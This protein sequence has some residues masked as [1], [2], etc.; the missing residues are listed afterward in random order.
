MKTETREQLE[1]KLKKLEWDLEYYRKQ[2]N[3]TNF[4]LEY[5]IKLLEEN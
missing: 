3:T 2:L 1:A 4:E 5:V